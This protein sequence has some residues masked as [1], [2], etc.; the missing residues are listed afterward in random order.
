M[1]KLPKE[2]IE[3]LK[4]KQMDED[5]LSYFSDI[6]LKEFFTIENRIK[7]RKFLDEKD[8]VIGLLTMGGDLGKRK[9][10]RRRRSTNLPAP[11]NHIPF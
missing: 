3:L 1:D 9:R 11:R 8:A 2:V 7:I 6:D 5:D 4:T 10:G